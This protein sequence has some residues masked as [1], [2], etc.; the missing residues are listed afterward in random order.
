[1]IWGRQ[2]SGNPLGGATSVIEFDDVTV[3]VVLCPHTEMGEGSTVDTAPNSL[4]THPS[5]IQLYHQ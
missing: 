1:M 5:H 2:V 3:L 4:M